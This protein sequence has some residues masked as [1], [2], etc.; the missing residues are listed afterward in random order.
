[1]PVIKGV[2]E[3][4]LSLLIDQ[5]GTLLGSLNPLARRSKHSR[6]NSVQINQTI[7]VS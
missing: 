7:D 4:S 3:K 2:N 1:M 6:N 5:P